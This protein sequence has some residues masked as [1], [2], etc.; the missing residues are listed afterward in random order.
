M[1]LSRRMLPTSSSSSS[2]SSR[3]VDAVDGAITVRSGEPPPPPPYPPLSGY[4]TIS[5]MHKVILDCSPRAPETFSRAMEVS[6][7][8]TATPRPDASY[9]GT[10][11]LAILYLVP[12]YLPTLPCLVS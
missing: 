1:K 4:H 6:S 2:S 5:H 11:E 3:D 9:V 12:D 10:F 7:S 8:M